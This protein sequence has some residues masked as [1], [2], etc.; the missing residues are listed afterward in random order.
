MYINML[1]LFQYQRQ[2]CVCPNRTPIK[3]SVKPMENID[4]IKIIS[5][6]GLNGGKGA[7]ATES[8]GE[9]NLADQ[10]VSSALRYRA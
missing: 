3:E 6:D 9:Q 5:V 4:G 2:Y 10:V 7:A 1:S 8:K